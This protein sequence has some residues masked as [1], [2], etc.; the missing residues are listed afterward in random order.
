M[1]GRSFGDTSMVTP[2]RA[3]CRDVV[4]EKSFR[5]PPPPLVV[6]TCV[7]PRHRPLNRRHEAREWDTKNRDLV[8]RCCNAR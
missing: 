4:K 5:T 3:E 8:Q 6:R 7:P 1:D 2:A